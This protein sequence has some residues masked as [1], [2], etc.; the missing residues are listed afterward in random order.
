MGCGAVLRNVLGLE[1]TRSAAANGSVARQA[2]T[3]QLQVPLILAYACTVAVLAGLPVAM[4][5]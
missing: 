3:D 4:V 5:T 2:D 1:T